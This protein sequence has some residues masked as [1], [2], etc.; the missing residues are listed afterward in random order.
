MQARNLAIVA[1][2][3][4]FGIGGMS[5]GISEVT[6]SGIGLAGITGVVLN[7]ILPNPKE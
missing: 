7:L 6:I 4:V 2:I 3:L 5:F 1:V